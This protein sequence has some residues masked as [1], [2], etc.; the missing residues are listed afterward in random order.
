MINAELNLSLL[1]YNRPIMPGGE[2]SSF[3]QRRWKNLL[4]WLEDHGFR[5]QNLPVDC[6]EMSFG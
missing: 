5:T 3:L 6:R 4:A 1:D 2:S